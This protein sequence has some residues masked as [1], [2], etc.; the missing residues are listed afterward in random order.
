MSTRQFMDQMGRVISISFPPQRIISLVPSQTELLFDLGLDKE[1]VGITKFCIHPHEIFKTKAKVGGTKKLNLK[2]IREL[3]PD[4]IIGNKEEND[5]GQVEELMKEFP[6]WMSDIND[7]DDAMA[8][9]NGIG[10]L[11]GK[12][13]KA[14]LL[15]LEIMEGFK[16]LKL[17]AKR[18]QTVA[19]FIWKDPYMVAG[20]DTFIN[21]ILNRAGYENFTILSRYPEMDLK[22]IRK[23][24]PDIVFLS[25]E[26]YPFKDVHVEEIKNICPLAKVLV[27]DGE[28]FSWYGSRLLHTAAYLKNLTD[29]TN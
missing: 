29:L 25:S 16:S 28:I 27:V 21:D 20:R 12:S 11:T 8:M 10:S 19:Y 5:R 17:S 1:L 13:Q 23:L 2:K 9:I 4:L 26:P 18:K 7:L 6:V 14:E 22:Q 15:T 24:Q 3:M